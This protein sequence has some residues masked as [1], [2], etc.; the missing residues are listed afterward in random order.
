MKRFFDRREAGRALADLLVSYRNTDA[1]VLGLPRGGVI[2]ATEVAFGLGLPLD[3]IVVLKLGLP[4]MPEVAM[5][6]IAEGAVDY[7]NR[8]LIERCGVTDD[9]V[10]GVE[11]IQRGILESRSS[12]FR[13]GRTR[14]DLN[15]R[16][17]IVVDDGIATGA[18]ARVACQSARKRGARDVVLAAPVAA[19]DTIDTFTEADSIA[20]CIV[21]P[22]FAAVGD[23][24]VQ[25]PQVTNDEVIAELDRADSLAQVEFGHATPDNRSISPQSQQTEGP[26]SA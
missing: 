10:D 17:A 4:V 12:L 8:D 13:H 14:V 23:H 18:T 7:L 2:V 19:S 11:R 24:Y 25:F 21:V 9:E 26:T 1:V 5:G 15:G 20:C 16:T 22:H 6:A 3:I